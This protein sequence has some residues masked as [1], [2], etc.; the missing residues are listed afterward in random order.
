MGFVY[1]HMDGNSQKPVNGT[2]DISELTTLGL[3]ATGRRLPRR[4]ASLKMREVIGKIR[5]YCLNLPEILGRFLFRRTSWK[6]RNEFIYIH[7]MHSDKGNKCDTAGSKIRWKSRHMMRFYPILCGNN[8][9]F[10]GLLTGIC[11]KKS[12]TAKKKQPLIPN[13]PRIKTPTIMMWDLQ[14]CSPI[15]FEQWQCKTTEAS[16]RN[17]NHHSET[18]LKKRYKYVICYHC[19]RYFSQ[20]LF[21]S[22]YFEITIGGGTVNMQK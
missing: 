16:G 12:D 15:G 13:R 22:W 19:N 1:I 2:R 4:V 6:C 5:L 10:I 8:A 18:G 11:K 21:A 20:N 14:Y 17:S 3:A 9:T 7:S